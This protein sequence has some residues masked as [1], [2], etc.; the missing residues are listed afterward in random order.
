MRHN[1]NSPTNE[2][3]AYYVSPLN[4]GHVNEHRF[5]KSFSRRHLA[6]S[7]LF[8]ESPNSK[9]RRIPLQPSIGTN[10]RNH[11]NI[12]AALLPEPTIIVAAVVALYVTAAQQKSDTQPGALP[13][14]FWFLPVLYHPEGISH[15][16]TTLIKYRFFPNLQKKPYN[17]MV[18]LAE[19][20]FIFRKRLHVTYTF[21]QRQ[22]YTLRCYRTA[23]FIHP[24]FG[25]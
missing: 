13:G 2:T 4:M 10:N 16:A 17:H 15:T 5:L 23:E 8:E 7:E 18:R 20:S 25:D 11:R 22:P 14:F 6:R 1:N 12:T 19:K 3:S 9:T 21:R 24:P